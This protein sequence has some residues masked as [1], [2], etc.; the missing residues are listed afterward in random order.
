MMQ[1]NTF[2]PTLLSIG[3]VTVIAVMW[4]PSVEAGCFDRRQPG[5]DW[6]GCS[7]TNK[8]L[9]DSNFNGSRF[10]DANLSLSSLDNSKFKGAS[11]V[12]TDMTRATARNTYFEDADLTKS[13]GYRA[14][15]D[16]ATLK[17]STMIKSE[18]FRASFRAAHIE[19]VDWSKSE[20]GRADFTAARLDKVSF[21]FSNL[22]RVLFADAQL[23]AVD[24]YGAYTYLT[25]F[26]GVDLRQVTNLSQLQI[27]LSCGNLETKLPEGRWVPDT[28][29]CIDD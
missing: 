22:S 20:L 21:K 16:R 28:W 14:I 8:M 29:P 9:D 26:E 18:Y 7:K 13:V 24:F 1:T 15:F 12:K 19:D 10:D 17:N 3:L 27:D 4:M 2:T 6:S 25:H 23:V 5:M 11:L